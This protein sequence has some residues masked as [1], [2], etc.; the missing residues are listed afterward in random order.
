MTPFI[1]CFSVL[2]N[3]QTGRKKH[4]ELM[5]APNITIFVVNE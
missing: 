2:S 1:I 3:K 5:T 4:E